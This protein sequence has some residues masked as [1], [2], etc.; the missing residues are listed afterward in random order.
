MPFVE[1]RHFRELTMTG[2]SFDSRRVQPGHLFVAIPGLTLDGHQFIGEAIKRG[3]T[4][5]VIEREV[6]VPPEVP[7]FKVCNARQALSHLSAQWWG[8]PSEKLHV[9][10][11][12]GTNGKTTICFLLEAI[13]NHSGLKA[14]RMG[15]IGY[16]YQ[17]IQGELTHTTPE[18]DEI[19]RLLFEMLQAKVSHVV[20]EA[21]SHAIDLNRCDDVAF[22]QAIFTNL[23]PEHLDYH[24]SMEL[25]FE[26]KKRLFTQ[27]LPQSPKETRA[28]LNIQDPYG[29]KL[30]EILTEQKISS[31]LWTF[32]THKPDSED[33]PADFYPEDWH[34]DISGLQAKLH[35]PQGSFAI[36]SPLIGMH[37]L[38][39]IIAAS[40]AALSAQVSLKHI[41]E[42]LLELKKIPGRLE[43]VENDQDIHVFVDYAHTPDALKNV[44]ATL[45]SL[46]QH[47]I[48]TVFGCGGDRDRDKR[49]LMGKEVGLFSDQAIVTSDNPRTEDPEKIIADILPGMEEAGMHKAKDYQVVPERRQAIIQALTQA[50]AGDVVLIA[51]KGHENYQIQ[52]TKKVPFD[53]REIVKEVL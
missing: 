27:L 29:K 16:A 50:Q 42:T 19:H 4:A 45:R 43:R 5:V 21:S 41:Q 46:G 3:A 30:Q 40:A 36:A 51:G 44:L 14:G 7:V 33:V 28:I 52:G 25:Y 6:A 37:N 34:F 12:T 22:D 35:S 18:A 1:K 11:I 15:T 2:L 32:S 17:D 53:D 39:N 38:A 48:I 24:K 26:S 23:T 8:H 9:T 20:M 49:P 47:K 10:G 31:A 13:L